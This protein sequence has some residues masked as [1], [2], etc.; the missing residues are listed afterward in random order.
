[1]VQRAGSAPRS[2]QPEAG[3]AVLTSAGTASWDL[4]S[5]PFH[6]DSRKEGSRLPCPGALGETEGRRE[7]GRR[8]WEM[9][10][11]PP[12][13]AARWRCGKGRGPPCRRRWGDP[14][15][16]ECRPLGGRAQTWSPHGGRSQTLS[17]QRQAPSSA[18]RWQGSDP[19]S[20]VARLSPYPL[21]LPA[22]RHGALARS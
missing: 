7:K 13:I 20:S 9:G 19:F 12:A 1:M 5:G 14:Q 11:P 10:E 18:P 6:R 4:I 2:P 22:V 16:Q 21:P 17:P 15:G 8:K 3:M